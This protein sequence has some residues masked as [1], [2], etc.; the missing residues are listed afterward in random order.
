M[1]WHC[2]KAYLS[3]LFGGII[4]LLCL[5]GRLFSS[6]EMCL[7]WWVSRLLFKSYVNE[8]LWSLM[9]RS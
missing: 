2:L 6:K 4:R 1:K 7:H 5:E 8:S 9:N 3:L